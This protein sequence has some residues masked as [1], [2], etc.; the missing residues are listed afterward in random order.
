MLDKV[1][2]KADRMVEEVENQILYLVQLVL[3]MAITNIL[4]CKAVVVL[5]AGKV[6]VL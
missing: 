6:A 3:R 4:Y 1:R 2:E 5:V